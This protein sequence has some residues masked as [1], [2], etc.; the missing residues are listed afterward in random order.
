MQAL[1]CV[2]SFADGHLDCF[3]FG[4]I[5]A[6]KSAAM[7]TGLQVS[8]RVPGFNSFGCICRSGIAGT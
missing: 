6:R 7:N 5:V 1:H 2:Y 3:H 4:V 8:V